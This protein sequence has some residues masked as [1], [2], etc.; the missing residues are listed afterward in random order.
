MVTIKDS[1]SLVIENIPQTVSDVMNASK[2]P[3]TFSMPESFVPEFR[4]E[5]VNAV[6]DLKNF[7]KGTAKFLPRVQGLPPYSRVI[8]IDS[9]IV[10]L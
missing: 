5:S 8:K 1:V 10:R 3:I 6:L 2:V 7:V 4:I 9:V